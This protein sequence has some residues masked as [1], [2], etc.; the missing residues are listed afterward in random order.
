VL[1]A[2]GRKKLVASQTGTI[3]TAQAL[4]QQVAHELLAAGAAELV[5][6]ARR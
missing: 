6:A 1:S 4:G 2:D 3:D 5:A